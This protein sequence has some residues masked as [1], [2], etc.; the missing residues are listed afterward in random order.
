MKNK[1]T[2]VTKRSGTIVPFNQNRI[3]NAIYRAAVAVGGR[4]KEKAEELAKQVV[5]ILNE[6]F[7]SICGRSFLKDSYEDFLL[8]MTKAA[9]PS[10][11]ASL[12]PGS[13]GPGAGRVRVTAGVAPSPRRRKPHHAPCDEIHNS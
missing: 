9:S 1:I 10:G 8:T 3:I 5:K 6:K 2:L 7:C 11:S 4:D 12:P 13:H